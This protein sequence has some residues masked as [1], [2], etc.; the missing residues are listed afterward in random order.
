M[1]THR[2]VLTGLFRPRVS[3]FGLEITTA[4]LK[5]VELRG[6]GPYTVAAASIRDLPT[7]AVAGGELLDLDILVE[8]L[9]EEH[10]V[11]RVKSRH[12]VSTIT[13]THVI[14]RNLTVPKLPANELDEAIKWE[15]ER[16]IPFPMTDVSFDYHVLPP[17]PGVS[18]NDITVT[19]V[20]ARLEHVTRLAEL[21]K[22]AGFEPLAIE[23]KSFAL[24]RTFRKDFEA[25]EEKELT[26][27]LEFGAANTTLT[28]VRGQTVVL[29]R[30]V[31]I[32]GDNF[33][34]ALMR[35]FNLEFSDAEQL[36]V[37]HG[38]VI[39]P[40]TQEAVELNG[41]Y[42]SKAQIYEALRPTL[43]DLTTEIRRSIDFLR[44]Q[45]GDIPISQLL[46]TGGGSHL[47]GMEEALGTILELTV[48]SPDPFAMVTGS[49]SLPPNRSPGLLAVPIG[50]A[51]RGVS[52]YD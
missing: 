38:S 34:E 47:E 25:A 42:I 6:Q 12:V 50:L 14:T 3:A 46:I 30:N 9:R 45:L 43:Y 15:A 23:T 1:T 33:T 4:S 51:M 44:V 11:A 10:R 19:V 8:M 20:A 26:L 16:Y 18:E 48:R 24:L 32:S 29:N 39:R 35:Y 2:S 49:P 37:H 52:D 27:L 36:K 31:G 21:I 40:K 5:L 41:S 28:V 7:G 22:R 13:N 17:Q